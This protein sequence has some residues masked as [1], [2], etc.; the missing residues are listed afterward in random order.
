MLITI[1]GPD[2]TGK[3][4]L[5]KLISNRYKNIEYIYFGNNL[6]NRKYK[7]FSSFLYSNKKGK[8][9][10]L[11]KYIFVFI[12][13]LFYYSLA[14]TRHIIS[15]RC[16]IDKYISSVVKNE[17]IRKHYHWLTLKLFPDPDYVILLQG[18][19][20]DLFLRKKEIS[21]SLISQYIQLYEKYVKSNKIKFIKIDTTTN[22]KKETFDIASKSIEILINEK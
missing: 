10:T 11:L 4:T 8:L 1:L 18:N 13:D 9:N 7:F 15:D 2:G 22:D 21:E 6:E 12:N 16:P 19:P 5:A 14:K 3:T 17:R 20:L